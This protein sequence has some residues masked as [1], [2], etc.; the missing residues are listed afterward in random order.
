M[1]A[2]HPSESYRSVGEVLSEDVV[3]FRAGKVEDMQ[4]V[5]HMHRE[6]QQELGW[7]SNSAAKIMSLQAD[8]GDCPKCGSEWELVKVENQFADFHYFD[9]ACKC[10]PRCPTCDTSLASEFEQDGFAMRC[11]CG[12][13]N[14]K[15]YEEK[16]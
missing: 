8:G 1:S 11:G 16:A 15:D 12:Y 13:G 7:I 14:M 5:I 3:W 6:K 2:K 10:Y 4:A 9:P